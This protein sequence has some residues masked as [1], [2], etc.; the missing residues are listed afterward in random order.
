MEQEEV[1]W[2]DS[3]EV[4][5]GLLHCG[6]SRYQDL[7]SYSSDDEENPELRSQRKRLENESKSLERDIS[8]LSVRL[9]DLRVQT[10]SIESDLWEK[11]EKLAQVQHQ[12]EELLRPSISSFH[13]DSR[14]AAQRAV[15][16]MD[17]GWFTLISTCVIILNL[18]T[19]AVEMFATSER[20][21]HSIHD[22]NVACLLFYLFEL[23]LKAILYQEKLL[24]GP[25]SHVWGHWVDLIVVVGGVAETW[26]LPILLTGMDSSG[27][28]VPLMAVLRTLRLLRLARVLKVANNFYT[29]DLSWTE[30]DQFHMFMLRVIAFNTIIL[31]IEADLKWSGFY[32]IE[33]ILLAI[34]TFE[35]AARLKHHGC[36]SFFCTK[37]D[38]F[39]NYLDFVIVWGSLL[40]QWL[41]PFAGLVAE[42]AGNPA[43]APMTDSGQM[44]SLASL[45]RIARL[46]RILR[47]V[48]LI[49]S[50][51]E[52]Y[53]LSMGILWSVRGM[54]W[55][56]VLAFVVLY[57][58]ALLGVRL[59]R[60]GIIFGGEDM[61]PPEVKAIFPSIHQS[62]WEFFVV[63]NGDAS[64]ME[65]L[66]EA[67]PCAQ[68]FMMLFMVFSSWAI[69]SIL[70][71]VVSENMIKSTERHRLEL[72]EKE[73]QVRW[74]LHRKIL[75]DVFESADSFGHGHLTKAE[76]LAW[77]ETSSAHGG[78]EELTGLRKHDLRQM[79]DYLCEDVV[80][81]DDDGDP[82]DA[83]VVRVVRRDRFIDGL[84]REGKDV[85]ERSM[86][87][88][89]KEV[90]EVK[91]MLSDLQEVLH[92]DRRGSICDS[93]TDRQKSFYRSTSPTADDP[94]PV[95]TMSL[96]LCRMN[97]RR[98]TLQKVG[99]T[100][101]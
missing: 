89:E 10:S 50:I 5:A 30:S 43:S 92:E 98:R 51:P 93:A 48:R 56:L 4:H 87:R 99:K 41:L 11:K 62:I 3:R 42:L 24:V 86:M 101:L 65:P 14:N 55:V 76:F 32:Y 17:S 74:E 64:A 75:C 49:K 95:A 47:L 38:I 22:L 33:Q 8:F 1:V 72:E 19:L 44:G 34:Y 45:L 9:Q 83:E 6:A 69:L 2:Q 36:R 63:M 97:K 59:V 70:T 26:V 28:G 39:W 94:S 90:L 12:I 60:D 40:D 68:D 61:T 88:L 81:E 21:R 82:E 53:Q 96:A 73:S 29:A 37:V 85:K 31:G 71:A 67:V 18:L 91:S 66:F 35:L 77:V 23:S 27:K 100:K 84:Q 58:M 25:C 7:P 54:M 80:V 16:F 20:L 13:A 46:L 78:V 79:F 15:A 52:L 57:V